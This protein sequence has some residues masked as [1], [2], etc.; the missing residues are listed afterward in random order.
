MCAGTRPVCAARDRVRGPGSRP[1]RSRRTGRRGQAGGAAAGEDAR[2]GGG[3]DGR[4][5]AP[6]FA[7]SRTSWSARAQ[8]PA[9]ARVRDRVRR[10]ETVCASRVEAGQKPADRSA[11]SGGGATG[12]E[13]AGRRRWWRPAPR[14]A[15]SR[16]SWSARA[17]DPACAR[18]RDRARRPATVCASRVEAGQKPADRS[19][20]SGGGA[21]G[22]EDA[23]RRRWWR[24]H[25]GS[26]ARAG[27][28]GGGPHHGS[29]ARAPVGAPAHRVQRVRGYETVCADTRP[30]ARAGPRPGRSRRTGRRGQA[31]G[32]PAVR[33]RGPLSVIA[34]VCSACA[35][36]LPSAV[37]SVQPSRVVAV[38]V[39]A[40]GQQHRLER[41]HQARAAAAARGRAPLVGHERRL[42]HRAPDPVAA[43]VGEQPVAARAPDPRRSRVRCRRAGRPG[44]PPRCPACSARSVVSISSRSRRVGRTD[45]GAERGVGAPAVQVHGE[46]DAEQVAVAQRFPARGWRARPRR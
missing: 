28:D 8:D 33:T 11:R 40:A 46:V 32:R 2:A 39:A 3:G 30:C 24:P 43:V 41:D 18:A 10:R 45:D 14:F 17:Q 12:G 37:R 23:G 25:H 4:R 36:R 38:V 34:M 26:L 22:G 20:R 7:G 6:R 44:P 42:V 21:T 9:C 13:D 5:P 1:G 31:V 29:L 19:A 16:T 15:G 35:A 27:G